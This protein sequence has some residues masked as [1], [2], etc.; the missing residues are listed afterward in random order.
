MKT[1]VALYDQR[2]DAKRAVRE[3]IVR[4]VARDRISLVSPADE[5]ESRSTQLRLDDEPEHIDDAGIGARP[6]EGAVSGVGIGAMIL[7]AAFLSLP[8]V[9]PVLAAGPL[10]AGIAASGAQASGRDLSPSLHRSGV[11]PLDAERY[12]DAV[13]RGHALVVVVS[14][15]DHV[16]DVASTLARHSPIAA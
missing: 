8:A 11:P 7:G 1:I 4:G 12:T 2:S 13:R 5:S 9:G 14:D 10:L 16:E 15:E 6:R 3:L